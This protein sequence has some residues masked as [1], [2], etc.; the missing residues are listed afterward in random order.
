MESEACFVP[1]TAYAQLDAIVA[2]TIAKLTPAE[3]AGRG[4]SAEARVLAVSKAMDKVMISAGY[5]LWIPTETLGDALVNR[6]A[7]APPRFIVDCDTGSLILM[8][9]AEILGMPTALVEV[10][11]PSSNSHNYVRWSLPQ[12]TFIDW[13]TNQ[14]GVC[15]TPAGQPA[16]QGRALSATETMGYA[17][18]LRAPIWKRNR[19]FDRAIADYHMAIRD[20]PDSPT[21]YN[22]L[23]WQ[24]ATTNWPGR[25]GLQSEAMA[26]GDKALS[27]Q[28]SS[29]DR[30]LTNSDI[31]NF[32]DTRACLLALAS[33]FKGAAAAEAKVVSLSPKPEFIERLKSFQA[34][35]PHDCT[36]TDQS[37]DAP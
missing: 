18:I 25:Q 27:L 24:V 33:D 13:D 21:A 16:F 30:R 2:G 23:A 35:T 32:G 34:S 20:R 5:G 36:G 37:D 9:I 31:A 3:R 19:A 15:T 1:D 11:L 14:R 7:G 26:S 4:V 17:Y 8:T 6:S 12:G 10:T 28:E 22:N 29:G